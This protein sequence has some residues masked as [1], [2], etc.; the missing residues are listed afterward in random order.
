VVF[1]FKEETVKEALGS[2]GVQYSINGV[3][4]EAKELVFEEGKVLGLGSW[5]E[6][7]SPVLV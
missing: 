3:H 2:T 4:L 6:V 1:N 5:M 7:G